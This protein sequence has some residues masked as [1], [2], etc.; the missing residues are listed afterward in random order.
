MLE[1][2]PLEW[3]QHCCAQCHAVLSWYTYSRAPPSFN[4]CSVFT[5]TRIPIVVHHNKTR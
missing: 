1:D 2:F 3:P 4:S 5:V